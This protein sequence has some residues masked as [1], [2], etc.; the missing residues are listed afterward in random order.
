MNYLKAV[1]KIFTLFLLLICN[2][3]HGYAQPTTAPLIQ[4]TDVKYLGAFALPQTTSGT[5]RFGYGGNGA[6]PYNDPT[7]GK[8]TLFVE[9]HAWYPGHVAQVEIPA[10]LVKSNNWE[11]L[12]IATVL[13]P[14]KDIT[15]GN[16]GT[17]NRNVGGNNFIY[18]MLAFNGRLIVGSS[19]SYDAAGDQN[20]SH[21]VSSFNLSAANDFQGYFTI[22]A[23]APPRALGGYMTSIPQEWRAAFGGPALTGNDSLSII[24][25]TSSGPAVT[26]FNPD[27]LGTKSNVTG[28]T[29]LFYPLSNPYLNDFNS[30]TGSRIGG[31][32]FPGGTRSVLFVG[33]N[34][35]VEYCYGE[36]TND[37]SLHKKPSPG[38]TYCYD[39]CDSS[40]GGHG[41]PYYHKILAY[42]ANDLMQVKN[43][44]KQPWQLSPY[45]SW[46]LTE[47]DN[48]GCGQIRSAGFDPVTNRIFV[49]QYFGEE[50]R[51][52]VYS[53]NTPTG[54]NNPAPSAP[55]NLRTN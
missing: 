24:S 44:I 35:N 2:T 32:A 54:I 31:I 13:Q 20:R 51:I 9:G 19:N 29:L 4:Q 30:Q 16:S 14:F 7:T 36:G 50:G 38:G 1:G 34:S 47:M 45:S 18:G 52:D 15:D 5:S 28:D 55:L 42:D 48:S 10:N 21:G 23:D 33:N 39:P 27:D 53:V 40:K 25:S 12:P 11:S 46:K 41:Y 3:E 6:T 8:Q 22:S 43:G 26:V 49:A 37:P 17:L